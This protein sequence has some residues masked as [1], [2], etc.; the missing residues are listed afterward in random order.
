MNAMMAPLVLEKLRTT[1]YVSKMP[2]IF[3]GLRK[4]C[5]MSRFSTVVPDAP[6]ICLYIWNEVKLEKSMMTFVKSKLKLMSTAMMRM[7]ASSF[8]APYSLIPKIVDMAIKTNMPMMRMLERSLNTVHPFSIA[9]MILR[10]LSPSVPAKFT[11]THWTSILNI[12]PAS[13]RTATPIERKSEP[14]R[15]ISGVQKHPYIHEPGHKLQVA[16]DAGGGRAG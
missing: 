15:L 14:M 1:S 4:L 7:R 6:A 12:V 5:A 13:F 3:I 16:S 2:V 9:V 11:M 8:F 10:P